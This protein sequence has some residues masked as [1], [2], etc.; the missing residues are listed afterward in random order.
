MAASRVKEIHENGSRGQFFL[1]KM[2]SASFWYFT[3]QNS[4]FKHIFYLAFFRE[5]R[6][7]VNLLGDTSVFR[8]GFFFFFFRR[9][10]PPVN[11][12]T[13]A[14]SFF[15]FRNASCKF[16]QISLVKLG[17]KGFASVARSHA[18]IFSSSRPTEKTWEKLKLF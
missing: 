3:E 1:R 15:F 14:T 16:V 4:S 12:R 8:A 2:R 11:L 7:N 17:W 10:V 13:F 9:P 5:S 18:D 6:V